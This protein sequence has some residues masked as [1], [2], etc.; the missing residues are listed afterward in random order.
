MTQQDDYDWLY[1]CGSC[2][3]KFPRS[4]CPQQ[5]G[6]YMCP[7]CEME[8]IAFASELEEGEYDY[9]AHT[10]EDQYLSVIRSEDSEI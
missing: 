1:K 2:A 9:I 7:H 6:H 10:K 4:M 5:E 8:I 3:Y